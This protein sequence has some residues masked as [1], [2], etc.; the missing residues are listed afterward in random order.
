MPSL[1][2]NNFPCAVAAVG[3]CRMFLPQTFFTMRFLRVS[4]ALAGFA[5]AASFMLAQAPVA[6]TPKPADVAYEAYMKLRNEKDA[7]MNQARF[8]EVANAGFGFIAQYPTYSKVGTAINSLASFGGQGK[9]NAANRL[10]WIT[11]AKFELIGQKGR[12][13]LKPEALTALASFEAALAFAMVKQDRSRET[14]Q[15]FREKIDVLAKMPGS[16]RFLSGHER[17]FGE[18]IRTG[19]RPDGAETFYKALLAHKDKKV[20]D[21]AKMELGLIEARRTAYAATFTGLDGKPIDFGK[22]RGKAVL[23]VFWSPNHQGSSD[24]QVA[25]KELYSD[26]RKRGLE[27]VGVAC[28]KEADREKVDAFIKSKKLPW[29]TY[30]DGKEYAGELA[31]KFNV[32]YVP[33]TVLL[34]K[35][36]FFVENALQ[37]SRY[38]REV[39]RI[40]GIK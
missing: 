10:A 7:K 25:L 24:A 15:A 28:A 21:M 40:L 20:Q 9:E 29:P 36:G 27:V 39:K 38:E 16:E 33:S 14:T 35:E 5:A 34:N 26:Y 1:T 23:I 31:T 4:L 13:D 37:P 3:Q 22:M 12:E 32:R 18:M 19:Q 30:F 17:D 8:V 2:I 6:S 11:Y